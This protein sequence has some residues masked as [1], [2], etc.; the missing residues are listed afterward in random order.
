MTIEF[1]EHKN[2]F[3]TDVKM[4]GIIKNKRVN[5]TP[6]WSKNTRHLL[7]FQNKALPL[8]YN[9]KSTPQDTA[10]YCKPPVEQ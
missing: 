10:K 9:R 1:I 7:V 6:R 2:S 8:S 3:L 5:P 4:L